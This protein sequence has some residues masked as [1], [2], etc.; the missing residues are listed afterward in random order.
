MVLPR[1]RRAEKAFQ[2]LASK[3]RRKKGTK[4]HSPSH[5]ELSFESGKD[6]A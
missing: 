5:S 2:A 1:S 6:F 3:A 4:T